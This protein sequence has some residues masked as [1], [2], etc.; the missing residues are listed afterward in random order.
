MSPLTPTPPPPP[1]PPPGIASPFPGAPLPGEDAYNCGIV[2]TQQGKAGG[3]FQRAWDGTKKCVGDVTGGIGGAFQPGPTRAMFQSDHAFDVFASPVTNPH[4]F[5]DPRSLTE[6]RPTFMW[7]STP[8]G[9][10]VFSGGN[11]FFLN[12]RGSVAITDRI[13]IVLHRAGFVSTD[14]QTPILDFGNAT[15]LSEVHIGPKFTIIRN[16][17]SNT[18]A[19]IGMAFE[20]PVGSGD[21]QQDTG[22]LTLRPYFSIA[23]NF[24][25]SDYGSFNFMNTTGYAYST[26]NQRTDYVYSSFHLDYEIAK[27]FYPLIEANY[28]YYTTN[29]GARAVN[30]EGG[31][32]FNFGAT[33]ISGNSELTIAGGFR[34]KFTEAVQMGLAGEYGLINTSRSLDNFRVTVDLIFRY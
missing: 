24:L 18:V 8:D 16:D 34:Y 21:V 11:N 28:V 22:S 13:S 10:P 25:R 29:G 32:L 7:Q 27:R 30:F 1:P 19:A 9:N 15:G 17:V 4:Y 3:F 2:N 31:N 23:Q 33:D 20:I 12:L 6:F 5:E 26:D 14:A